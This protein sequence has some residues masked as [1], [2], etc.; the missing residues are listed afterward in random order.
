MA[1]TK[2]KKKFNG[3][4][5]EVDTKH[6]LMNKFYNI[7]MNS[8]E[9]QG[10]THEEED[11]VMRKLWS[12]GT[13]SAFYMDN[14]DVVYAPYSV[15]TY[16]L[17]DTPIT[18]NF[19]NERNVPNFK[20]SGTNG[21]D[22][23][24]GFA[25]RNHKP[26]K[27]VIQYYVDKMCEVLMSIYVNTQT[28]KLPFLVTING[29]NIESANDVISNIYNNELAIFMTSDVAQGIGVNNT[30]N[31]IID[32]LWVQYQNYLGECLTELGIDSNCI[33]FNRATAD[34]TNANN[35]LINIIDD[36]RVYELQAFF[37]KVKELFGKDV[38]VVSRHI[39]VESIH[40]DNDYVE[41]EQD[42]ASD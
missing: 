21:V 8:V 26:V 17:Y 20:F 24:I 19:I 12:E 27:E 10:L 5:L 33:N 35:E 18:L 3:A 41:E 11:Y 15:N 42:G 39:K 14:V 28:S 34:Q 1:K 40:D 22:C 32:K 6:I 16:G 30:G 23:C 31:Y 4:Q 7:F 2:L 29:D 38:Q 37:D 36:G 25:N 9:L 13:I